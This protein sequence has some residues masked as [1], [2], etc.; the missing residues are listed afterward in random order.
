M[1]QREPMWTSKDWWLWR[2]RL[3]SKNS[4]LSFLSSY[5]WLKRENCFVLDYVINIFIIIISSFVTF[6]GSSSR[7]KYQ[8]VCLLNGCWK[9]ENKK[10][11]EQSLQLWYIRYEKNYF[12]SI[13]TWTQNGLS[14]TMVQSELEKE[15]MLRWYLENSTASPHATTLQDH[16]GCSGP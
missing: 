3:Y 11:F 13:Q 15:I 7:S 4:P 12:Q 2:Q 8:M 10:L 16:R 9:Y 1:F 5:L 6:I 14:S